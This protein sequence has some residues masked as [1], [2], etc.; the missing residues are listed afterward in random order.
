[1]FWFVYFRKL[2]VFGLLVL[3]FRQNYRN[4][5]EG[6]DDKVNDF[7]N[8]VDANGDSE[9]LLAVEVISVS[10]LPCYGHFYDV[11]KDDQGKANYFQDY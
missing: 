4:D 2:L 11:F 3:D 7:N 8:Q 9:K 1:M 5:L 10:N 6:I